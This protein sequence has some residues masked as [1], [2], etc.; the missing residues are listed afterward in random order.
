[1]IMNY[2]EDINSINEIVLFLMNIVI[3]IL[4]LFKWIKKELKR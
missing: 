4:Y 2:I 1:M 3:L